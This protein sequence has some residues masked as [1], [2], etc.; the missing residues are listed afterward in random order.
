MFGMKWQGRSHVF[1]SDRA[2]SPKAILD[3]YCLKKWEGPNILLLLL[4]GP[5]S[6]RCEGPGPTGPLGDYD[7]EWVVFIRPWY[8]IN[9]SI[10]IPYIFIWIRAF[11]RCEYPY[12]VC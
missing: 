11:M 6:G 1:E 4:F 5:K 3:P 9:K 12:T 8:Q 7:P 10:A 2:Q